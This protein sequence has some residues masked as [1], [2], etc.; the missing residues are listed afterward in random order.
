MAVIVSVF[1]FLIASFSA[2]QDLYV[3]Q[4]GDTLIAIARQYDL[5]WDLLS[6]YNRIM[7]PTRMWVGTVLR[8]PGRECVFYPQP[9]LIRPVRLGVGTTANYDFNDLLLLARLIHAEARGESFEGQVA[10]GAVVRNR[11]YSPL[12]PATMKEVIYQPGQFTPAERKI[13]PYLPNNSSWE[14]AKRALAGDDPTGGAIFFYN[15]RTTA[16]RDYWETRT[17][18]T[19]IGNHN[20]AL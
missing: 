2:A 15:P 17:V 12:F 18:I 16:N 9:D 14:A 20:F 10:V 4:P 11:V 5:P 19:V 13:L 7:D 8:I 3:V 6:G 1:L